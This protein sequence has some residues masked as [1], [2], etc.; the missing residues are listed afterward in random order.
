MTEWG[1]ISIQNYI[2]IFSTDYAEIMK[3]G[4]KF[5][6]GDRVVCM[7]YGYSSTGRKF[8]PFTGC[9]IQDYCRH[10]CNYKIVFDDGD[11]AW[12]HKNFLKTPQD[13]KRKYGREIK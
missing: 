3:N 4:N 9:T 1:R 7:C 5:N 11:Y 12:L 6:T 2:S 8:I 13:V 10:N